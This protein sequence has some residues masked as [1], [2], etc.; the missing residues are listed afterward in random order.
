MVVDLFCPEVPTS[1]SPWSAVSICSSDSP[2]RD[3]PH[4]ERY[5]THN[6]DE[7]ALPPEGAANCNSGAASAAKVIN[8]RQIERENNIIP[9]G[10]T[11]A[12]FDTKKN[13][14]HNVTV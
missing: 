2:A 10:L 13:L 6:H 7:R 14:S 9:E 5:R 1:A 3:G 12:V 8:T 4:C 11:A